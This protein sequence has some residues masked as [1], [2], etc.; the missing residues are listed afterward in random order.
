MKGRIGQIREKWGVTWRESGWKQLPG[1]LVFAVAPAVLGYRLEM[2]SAD[3]QYLLPYAVVWNIG[4]MYWLQFVLLLLTNSPGLSVILVN[5]VTTV[6][7][8]VN[9]FVFAYRGEP[10]RINDITAAGTAAQVAANYDYTPTPY[11]A[12][13]W[14]LAAVVVV[15]AWVCGRNIKVVKTGIT[16]RMVCVSAGVLVLLAG[17]YG[18]LGT[19][20]LQHCGFREMH[21]YEQNMS[22]YYNGFLVDSCIDIQNARVREPA[23]YSEE[24]VKDYLDR[25]TVEESVWDSE[26]PHVILIMNE[27]F[28]DLRILGNLEISDENMEFF[29]SLQENVI[30]GTVN[31][32]VLGGGT[33]N[34]EFEVFTGCSMGLLPSGYYAYQQ[35]VKKPLPSIV[36]AMEDAGYTTISMHPEIASNWNR[37]KVYEYLGF[38]RMLWKEDFETGEVVHSGLSDGDTYRKVI[39]LYE[40]RAEGEK[41]FVFDLTMQNH[42]GYEESNVEHTVKGVNVSSDEA[43]TYL[44]L[45]RRSDED[46][47][48][49]IH[50]FEQ[51]EEE[52]IICMFGDH[53][54]KFGDEGFYQKLA[55]QTPDMSDLDRILNEYKTPFL[56]WSNRELEEQQGLDISMNYLGVL[57]LESVG[58]KM[59]AYFS[60]LGE[61][62]QEYPIIT[63]NGYQDAEENFVNWSGED[64]EFQIYRM[65]QYHLLFSNP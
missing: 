28:G 33:A 65:L 44:S 61:L 5:L 54:P 35:C 9:Y 58:V 3:L 6:L 14:V 12:I 57:L 23:G 36:S 20:L 16:R 10:V 39:E 45:I 46:F 25:Y 50:Y 29:N 21:G 59:P 24:T 55:A 13:T 53:L 38:D 22:F 30:R 15:L 17:G 7:Y 40:N 11:M 18:L 43:D 64:D 52:V 62:M 1:W 34:S 47:E 27:S 42:G 41:L 32:S 49:L 19:E 37:D 2:L 48:Q 4:I 26:L 63:V 8:S 56:I 60:Y 51:A 31:A